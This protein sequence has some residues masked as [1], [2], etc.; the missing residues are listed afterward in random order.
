MRKNEKLK[1]ILNNINSNENIFIKGLSYIYNIN[2]MYTFLETIEKI[3]DP[4]IFS[5]AILGSLLVY[6]FGFFIFLIQ[7]F[8]LPIEYLLYIMLIAVILIKTAY[9]F[10]K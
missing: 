9:I 1:Y 7:G 6:Y 5:I 3:I 2:F 4:K 10:K 8:L